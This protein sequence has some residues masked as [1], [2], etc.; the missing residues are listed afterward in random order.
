MVTI[1]TNRLRIKVSQFC[2]HGAFTSYV[3]VI[4]SVLP[5]DSR[6]FVR[7]LI[8][9][10]LW[11]FDA[12]LATNFEFWWYFWT[13]RAA[14][15]THFHRVFPF[16]VIVQPIKPGLPE[17]GRKVR[18]VYVL[19]SNCTCDWSLYTGYTQKNGVV[20]KVNKKFISHLTRAQRTPSAAAPCGCVFSKPCTKL[21]LHCN[22]R[23]GHLKTEHTES[24][25]L[26]RR[27]LGKW[28]HGPAVSM[29]SELL[30]AHEKLG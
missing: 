18:N 16:H 3:W 21:T 29:R 5:K 17:R 1:Y 25:F 9:F 30:A 4:L 28:P 22:H 7:A 6:F 12:P 8:N 11:N 2:P 14:L 27:H 23:S 26:L 13:M 20:S 15:I 10:G 24:L 19:K